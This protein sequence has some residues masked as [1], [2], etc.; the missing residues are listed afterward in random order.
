MMELQ[1]I[2]KNDV[3]EEIYG[4]EN[5]KRELKSA[6]ISSRHVIIVGPPGIGKT[7]LVKN[8]A[9]HLP[10]IEVSD[11]GFNCLPNDPHCPKCKKNGNKT[12]IISGVQRFIRVQGSPDLTVED[13]IGDIDPIKALQF[14]PQSVEAFSPGKIFKA[15]NG[16]LFFDELNRCPE[17]LQNALL[18]VLEEGTTTIGSY[19]V[20]IPSNF[21]F[22]A[23]MNPK[24]SNTER[25]SDVLLD[26]FDII[27]M[28]YP[29]TNEIEEKIV[30]NKGKKLQVI[31]SDN[32]ISFIVSFVR[33]LRLNPNLELVPSV[34]ATLGLY[35]RAQA[36]AI[37][38][39]RKEVTFK[40]IQDAM[41]SVLSHRI[42]LK[43]SSKFL[44]KPEQLL[45]KELESF[46]QNHREFKSLSQDSGETDMGDHP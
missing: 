35:E 2:L 16:I 31:F 11:C 14:G 6:L 9:K 40:D 4:Q 21:I 27:Q 24:D 1:K 32:L 12:K 30:K 45:E 41:S 22:I 13:L 15:N 23:T 34:R 42:K 7:T 8:L 19:E 5:V 10:E 46:M 18:Q 3:F 39:N 28:T 26:R 44:M 33:D 20:D 17:K 37:L 29:K 43:P 38:A 25:L 36:N